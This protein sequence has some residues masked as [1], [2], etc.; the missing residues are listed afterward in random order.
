MEG[1]K[2]VRAMKKR[3]EEEE[4]IK[5]GRGGGKGGGRKRRGKRERARWKKV[6][7]REIVTREGWEMVIEKERIR[8]KKERA[9]TVKKRREEGQD[10]STREKGVR[11]ENREIQ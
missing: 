10:R 9:G 3:N 6:G 5:E 8:G 2:T 7:V 1:I 11:T 4:C